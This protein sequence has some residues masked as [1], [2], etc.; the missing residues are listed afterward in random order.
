MVPL[1]PLSSQCSPLVYLCCHLFPL[2]IPVSLQHPCKSFLTLYGQMLRLVVLFSH[3]WPLYRA[4]YPFS[5]LNFFLSHLW[6]RFSSFLPHVYPSRPSLTLTYPL[7]SLVLYFNPLNPFWSFLSFTSPSYFVRTLSFSLTLFLLCLPF[8]PSFI[9]F[10]LFRLGAPFVPPL[11]LLPFVY[12]VVILFDHCCP[13]P[14]VSVP[15]LTWLSLFHCC[16]PPPPHP[17]SLLHTCDLSLLLLPLSYPRCSFLQIIQEFGLCLIVPGQAAW[18]ETSGV[19]SDP[20]VRI[21]HD[22]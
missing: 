14:N 6:L 7:L 22:G 16:A 8:N 1:W 2:F 17:L 11:S 12:L 9:P 21:N 10:F 4:L 18:R 19:F 20:D 15:C 5:T 13:F 3:L